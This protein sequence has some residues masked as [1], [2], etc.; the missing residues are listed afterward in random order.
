MLNS[1]KVLLITVLSLILI[2]CIK[3]VSESE[4]RERLYKHLEVR[5]GEPFEIGYMGMRST[6]KMMWYEAQILPSKYIGTEKANDKYYESTGT[7]RIVKKILGEEIAGVGDVYMGVRL[8]EDANAYFLPKLQEIF[9]DQVLPVLDID[10]HIVKGNGNFLETVEN[11]RVMNEKFY[12]KGG[13]YIWGRIDSLEDKERFR[14]K[15]FKFIEYMKSN[16]LF[17]YTN[18]AFYILDERSLVPRFDAEIGDKLVE[19]REELKTAD[20]FIKYRKELLKELDE[21]FTKLDKEYILEKINGFNR[22]YLRELHKNQDNKYSI[23]RHTV[24]RSPK[25]WEI[26]SRVQEYKKLNYDLK[27]EVMLY[28]TI[29]IDYREYEDKKINNH[30]WEG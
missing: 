6:D 18:L 28:N 20:E 25:Y 14:E 16:N 12:T 22:T 3:E 10:V 19:A 21:D 2:S 7:V 4:A 30:E 29:K 9:G 24:I 11:C 13:I 15:I 8:N 1:F 23:I 26:E 17:E 27:N 5:Y